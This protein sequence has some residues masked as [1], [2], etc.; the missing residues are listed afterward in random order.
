MKRKNFKIGILGAVLLT[1]FLLNACNNETRMLGVY[2]KKIPSDQL[3]TFEIAGNI[4]VKSF[5][6]KKVNWTLGMFDKYGSSS[7][8]IIQ[9][10]QGNHNIIVDFWM[11][12]LQAAITFKDIE[13][14][15]NFTAGNTYRLIAI[16]K[17]K[18]EDVEVYSRT[19]DTPPSS[20]SFRML[21][22]G[23]L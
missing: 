17:I 13:F 16:P 5:N 7:Q 18:G 15:Y 3:C 20:V 1:V 6:G 9:I 4:T 12:G 22:K 19:S 23:K 11:G 10:P 14:E 8:S 21:D 2:D